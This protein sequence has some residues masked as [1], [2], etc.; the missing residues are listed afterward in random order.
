MRTLEKELEF[1][2]LDFSKLQNAGF[3]KIGDSFLL[4]QNIF[5]D[6]FEMI[7]EI[8]PE[9]QTSLLI[10]LE[11]NEEYSLV[12]VKSSTGE[13]VGRVRQEYEKAL[14]KILEKCAYTEIFKAKQSKELISY[15]NKK[16]KDELEFLWN[17]LPKT[18]IVRNKKNEK[19]YGILMTLKK[20][21]LGIESEDLV[22]VINVKYQKNET[23]NVVD[24]IA[25][26]PG[27]HMNK[28]SWISIKLDGT[29]DNKK[30]FNL[31]DNSYE[32]SL[33]SK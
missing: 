6:K 14:E 27:Y 21:K 5:D 32:L 30:L 15:I 10:D 1:K 3:K 20:S 31:V 8:S 33:K 26:F 17:D 13:F 12:D 23:E 25:V 18:A 16:Y 24:N 11:T 19:W 29:I 22:E 7:V 2:T 28:K 9:K 4:K